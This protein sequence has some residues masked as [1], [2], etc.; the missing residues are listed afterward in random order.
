MNGGDRMTREWR[1]IAAYRNGTT[2]VVDF[3]EWGGVYENRG[4]DYPGLSCDFGGLFD[5]LGGLRGGCAK[6]KRR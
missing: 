1:P 2:L 5:F 3:R 6:R 4:E